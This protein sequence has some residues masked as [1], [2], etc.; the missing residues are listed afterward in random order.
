M[1]VGGVKEKILAAKRSGINEIILSSQ[2]K[3]DIMMIDDDYLKGLTYSDACTWCSSYR[4]C[5]NCS[6]SVMKI[7]ILLIIFFFPLY[8]FSQSNSAYQFVNLELSPRSL[9]MGG[10]LIS[11]FDNDISLATV[12]P[13]L[14]NANNDNDLSLNYVDYFS[15]IS[16]VSFQYSKKIKDFAS[17]LIG[18]SSIDYGVFQQTN[19]IGIESGE[20][21]ASDQVF[22]LGIGKKINEKITFGVSL[23]LLNSKYENYQSSAFTSNISTTYLN[24]KGDFSATLLA[25]NI[26]SKISA[27]TTIDEIIP[28][29]LQFGVSKLLKHLPFRYSLVFHNLQKYDISND[30]SLLTQTDIETG[31]LIQKEEPF[32]KKILRHFILGGEL[33]LFKQIFVLRGGLNFQ[34]RFNMSLPSFST[35]NGFSF[36]VGLNLSKFKFNFS[37]SSY[38]VS[39]NFNSFSI[40]TNLSTFGL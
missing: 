40:C 26:G 5:N 6:I 17:I 20:F 16:L 29:E 2:N 19:S 18:I 21:S 22:T 4:Y 11:I 36:G 30:Y 12:V 15:D 10:S 34:K 13:S 23:N 7:N 27:Y 31:L 8:L 39:G 1:P 32:A 14:I 3:K 24:S 9:A 37:R 25:K 38:H 33:S 35:A 28:F